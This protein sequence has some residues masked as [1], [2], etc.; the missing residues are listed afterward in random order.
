MRQRSSTACK[1]SSPFLADHHELR[2]MHRLI[3]RNYS[4]RRPIAAADPIPLAWLSMMDTRSDHDAN[5]KHA[6]R[7]HA[8]KGKPHRKRESARLPSSPLELSLVGRHHALV[9]AIAWS[10]SLP[11]VAQ[12]IQ[13]GVTPFVII[14]MI[15]IVTHFPASAVG[16]IWQSARFSAWR[17]RCNLAFT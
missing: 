4:G 1:G 12:Q 17:A 14:L 9:E 7:R 2:L 10:R 3:R 5:H 16:R 15:H 8:R 6:D 11:A 13:F